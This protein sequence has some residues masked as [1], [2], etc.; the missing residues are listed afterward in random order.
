MRM[1]RILGGEGRSFYHC[2]SRVIERRF[3][4]KEDEKEYFVRIMRRLAA[5]S[6]VRILTYSLMSNHFHLLLE[7]P[8]GDAKSFGDE[9]ILRRL[10]ILYDDD[11]IGLFK[12][13]LKV[14]RTSGDPC[15]I[16]KVRGPVEARMF[17]LSIFMRELKQRF[18]Q[19][20]NRREGRNGPLWEGRFRSVLVSGEPDA[21]YMM[22]L[23]IELNPLRAGLCEDMKDYRWCGYG[24]ALGGEKAAVDGLSRL[25]SVIEEG[26]PEG[27]GVV[28][29]CWGDVCDLYRRWLFGASQPRGMRDDGRPVK[30]GVSEE[31]IAA[32]LSGEG[33]LS[34]SELLG[35]RVRYMTDG[36]AFGGKA[37]VEDV[38]C[39]YRG[40]FGNKRRSGARKMRGGDWG[41]L[42]NLRDLRVS[43]IG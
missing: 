36:V 7:V 11:V 43:P 24:A 35:C 4:F 33:R 28:L 26:R 23:Y 32:V 27:M 12:M 41:S 29:S 9:E 17:D 13:R 8:D 40:Q 31:R 19:W 42:V 37:F 39:R 5:F 16:E 20:Y 21:L 38:F 22:G 14:A 15:L 1:M 10:R 18:T 3:I 34:R 2:M 6:G 30:M 25:V